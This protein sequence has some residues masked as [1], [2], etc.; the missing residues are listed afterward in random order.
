[1]DEGSG[2]IFSPR[3]SKKSRMH[4]ALQPAD[5]G[6]SAHSIAL[7]AQACISSLCFPPISSYY[8]HLVHHRFFHQNEAFLEKSILISNDKINSTFYYTFMKQ[9]FTPIIIYGILI[10]SEF[11]SI[12]RNIFSSYKD[13][14]GLVVSM[15]GSV[16]NG[17]L[18]SSETFTF[19]N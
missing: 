17:E 10:T 1:M 14:N 4:E 9:L 12:E 3:S 11:A 16:L 8:I 5:F 19:N 7:D 18:F 15:S 2:R 6:C 13:G